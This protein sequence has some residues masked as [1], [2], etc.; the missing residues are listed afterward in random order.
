VCRRARAPN[1]DIMLLRTLGI[2]WGNENCRTLPL[3][4]PRGR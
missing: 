3:M 2:A 1:K 4:L